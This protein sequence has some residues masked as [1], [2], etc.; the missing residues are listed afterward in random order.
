MEVK[1]KRLDEKAVMPTYATN[2]SAGLDLTAVRIGVEHSQDGVPVIVYD[3]QIAVEIPEGHVGL[4]FQRS[5]ISKYSISMTNAVGVIDSDYRGP[6]LLKYKVTTNSTPVIY[7]EGE[8][9]GQLVIVP[10]PRIELIE[11]S[12][13]TETERGEGGY[14]STDANQNGI[15]PTYEPNEEAGV[16]DHSYNASKEGGYQG[17]V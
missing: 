10:I 1:I 11:S 9:V 4:I 5:S 13:L 15:A 16:V 14:G 7:T 2:G 8:R 3:T 17:G 12:E 6:I